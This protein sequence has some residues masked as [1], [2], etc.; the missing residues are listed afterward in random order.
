MEEKY[1]IGYYYGHRLDKNN[2][3]TVP[4]AFLSVVGSFDGVSQGVNY[5][6]L[7][8]ENLQCVDQS[9]LLTCC[10]A[11]K[12]GDAINVIYNRYGRVCKILK[13]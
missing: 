9:V 1:Y 11:L 2:G 13:K 5:S 3:E 8:A 12:P 4:Y 7:R 10:A 6:G